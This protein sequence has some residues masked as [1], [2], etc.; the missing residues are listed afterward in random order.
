MF[1]SFWAKL[2]RKFAAVRFWSLNDSHSLS[3]RTSFNMKAGTVLRTSEYTNPI[4]PTET[5]A[6]R[7]KLSSFFT[8]MP[9]HNSASAPGTLDAMVYNW[10]CVSASVPAVSPE[11]GSIHHSWPPGP[12]R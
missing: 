1:A 9:L 11:D 10:F 2:G 4:R 3:D 7:K 6:E 8:R 5:R 12:I